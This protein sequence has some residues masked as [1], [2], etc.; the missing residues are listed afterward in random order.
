MTIYNCFPYLS[1]IN[2]NIDG[3]V[4]HQ[5]EMVPSGEVVRPAWPKLDSPV[6]NHLKNNI[7][8][9]IYLYNQLNLHCFID[10]QNQPGGVT[11]EED[12]HDG[13][14][15]GGHGGVPAVAL[16]DAVVY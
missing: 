15:Q 13:E 6:L 4:D 1:S 10:I 5:H 8:G 2:D 3:T 14:Q 12:N 11:E 16:G 7:L 9:Q